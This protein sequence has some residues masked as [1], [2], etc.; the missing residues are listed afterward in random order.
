MDT[1]TRPF[2]DSCS[3]LVQGPSSCRPKWVQASQWYYDSIWT[4]HIRPTEDQNSPYG[5]DTFTAGKSAMLENFSWQSW[6]WGDWQKAF[7]WD[8]AAVPAGPNGDVIAPANADVMAIPAKAKHPDQSW[9]V[10]KWMSQPDVMNRLCKVYGCVPV[11]KSLA[12]S[13]V[14]DR[15][16]EYPG[17][18]FQV[19]IDSME[20]LD[21][22]PNVESWIPS[23]SEVFDA[24]NKF[25]GGM[26]TGKVKNVEESLNTLNGEVQAIF[27]TYWANHK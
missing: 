19:F 26:Q 4:W 25:D 5:W 13:W 7:K 17:V 8:V 22:N 12:D 10:I 15:S 14:K 20:H 18:D 16:A 27:D 2:D 3:T 21:A 1:S 23:W 6:A 24:I 9:E 11:R